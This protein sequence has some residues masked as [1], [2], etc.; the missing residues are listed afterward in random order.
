MASFS[1]GL[2]QVSYADADE[3]AAQDEQ[4]GSN[5]VEPKSVEERASDD[6]PD[7]GEDEKE[8]TEQSGPWE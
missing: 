2:M 4:D 1:A 6:E 7:P 8:T 3:V 5:D